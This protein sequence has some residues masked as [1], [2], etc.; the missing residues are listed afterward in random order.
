[1]KPGASKSFSPMN[2]LGRS[3][4]QNTYTASS[5][6]PRPVEMLDGQLAFLNTFDSPVIDPPAPKRQKTHQADV[7]DIEDDNSPPPLQVN[8]SSHT[9]GTPLS[10]T[11]M[12]HRSAD[13]GRGFKP[14]SS[15]MTTSRLT[16][17]H[18]KKSRRASTAANGGHRRSSFPMPVQ[19]RYRSVQDANA[20]PVIELGGNNE[21]LSRT[22]K[23]KVPQLRDHIPDECSE[24]ELQVENPH[25]VSKH[26]AN[27]NL[28]D[29]SRVKKPVQGRAQ[30]GGIVDAAKKPRLLNNLLIPRQSVEMIED[31]DELLEDRT[32][33][34]SVRN[35]ENGS[36]THVPTAAMPRKVK[37][38]SE[39]GWP[40]LSAR[41]HGV[42]VRSPDLFLT[43]CG[44]TK[45]FDLVKHHNASERK[46][47]ASLDMRKINRVEADE[48]S[49]IR[50]DGGVSQGTKYRFDLEFKDQTDYL[51]FRNTFAAEAGTKGVICKPRYLSLFHLFEIPLTYKA[52]IWRKFLG[53]L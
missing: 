25:I 17:P 3:L 18:R 34:A 9:P 14:S 7:I 48:H 29:V 41:S 22:T 26:F 51:I 6:R 40:L 12:S 13:R 31:D 42:E 43:R 39:P 46:V 49:Q 20:V 38:T 23:T 50:L 16:D 52:T 47:Y 53:L 27:R 21:P 19:E 5:K 33:A 37:V 36:R 1:M 45:T 8:Y 30:F 11:S 32:P 15:F 4:H 24:D 2:T 35:V 10:V 44:N 28:D